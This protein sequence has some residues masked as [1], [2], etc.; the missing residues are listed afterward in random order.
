VAQRF[1]DALVDGLARVKKDREA[2]I[3]VIGKY[4]KVSDPQVVDATY[5][6]ET[7][8]LFPALPYVRADQLQAT[9]QVLS[10]RNHKVASVNVNRMI[11]NS[12]VQSAADRSV[13]SS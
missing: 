9:V 5:A 11:D 7:S 2:T 10:G 13:Q 4:L 3:R 1:V 12:F 8:E 6:F